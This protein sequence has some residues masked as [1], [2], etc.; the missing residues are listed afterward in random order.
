MKTRLLF[1]LGTLGLP[2]LLMAQERHLIT[3]G[4]VLR[5]KDFL[6]AE[7]GDTVL[8]QTGGIA[9]I[10]TLLLN[11]TLEIARLVDRA[12]L[13][14]A[15]RLAIEENER[16]IAECEKLYSDLIENCRREHELHAQSIARSQRSAEELSTSLQNTRQSLLNANASLQKAREELNK[17]RLPRLW[18][19]L[20][21]GAAGFGLGAIVVN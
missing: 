4:Y 19:G 7:P 6:V 3:E 21:I 2:L 8:F 5:T 16:K 20:L 1:I 13:D 17:R 15:A 10:D 12:G 14:V 11:T 18:H 9:L